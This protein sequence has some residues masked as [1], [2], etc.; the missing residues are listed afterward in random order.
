VDFDDL[1]LD[2]VR[3]LETDK[4]T[5][6]QLHERFRWISVDEY[7]D[8]NLAQARLLRL[9]T[10][11][12]ANLC[13][14][15]DPDQAI[16]GFRGADRRYFLSFA[17]DFPGAELLRLNQNYR[18]TQLIL[19]AASQ[20]IA[21]SPDVERLKL[22]SEF[23][24]EVKLDIHPAATDKAEAEY[25]VHQI[26]QMVGGTSLYSLDSGRVG[27]TA[28]AKRAFG[29]FAVLYRLNAQSQ[30]LVE[31]LERSGIP[32]QTVGEK[33][34]T[35]YKEIRELLAYLWLLHAPHSL[36]H[37]R[38]L[39]NADRPLFPAQTMDRLARLCEEQSASCWTILQQYAH[40]NFLNTSQTRRLGQVVEALQPLHSILGNAPVARLIEQLQPSLAQ[41]QDRL[42]DERQQERIQQLTRRAIPFGRELGGFLEAQALQR[43]SDFYDPRADRVT[44]MTLHAAKGLEFPVVFITGCEEG[45]L[46]YVA[47]GKTTDIEE[48]RRLF[49]VGMTRAQQKLVLTRAKRR[50]LF[51]QF[52][53]PGPARF[54]NDIEQTLIELKEMWQPKMLKEQPV[55]KQL[56]LF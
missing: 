1:L 5:L 43:E 16:Y 54:L 52:Q 9:L 41:N 29:D 3:L 22:W 18:S 30:P 17:Q 32:F 44:L 11:G 27:S 56:S 6:A 8:I 19:N 28:A 31:A 33:P 36:V 21:R 2:S 50:L 14:I 47:T 35:E 7:Q 20:V 34:L 26:E 15:G 49:Y 45:L 53:E 40:W 42:R 12:G 39:L 51:G 46:P 24:E 10:V 4:T 25:V 55:H 37:L 38:V 48:E 13:A 23:I